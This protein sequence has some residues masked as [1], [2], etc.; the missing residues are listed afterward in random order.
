MVQPE[1]VPPHP[2]NAK[3]PPDQCRTTLLKESGV[4]ELGAQTLIDH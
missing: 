3:E 2:E 4:G 1:L